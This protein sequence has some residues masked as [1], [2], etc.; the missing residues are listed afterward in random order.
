[1]EV[2]NRVAVESHDEPVFPPVSV[3]VP[4]AVA[5]P[6]Q[7]VS[8]LE[9]V[10][11]EMGL[12]SGDLECLD[13]L[14]CNSPAEVAKVIEVR[15]FFGGLSP[16]LSLEAGEGP[17]G[18]AKKMLEWLGRLSSVV[19]STAIE[20]VE[21]RVRMFLHY[22][23]GV[24]VDALVRLAGLPEGQGSPSSRA[25]VTAIL[26]CDPQT[27]GLSWCQ[28]SRE[29]LYRSAQTV[30]HVRSVLETA[31]G[32]GKPVSQ[33]LAVI[34]SVVHVVGKSGMDLGLAARVWSA[35]GVD[36]RQ[37]LSILA[38]GTP[39]IARRRCYEVLK[40]L[41]GAVDNHKVTDVDSAESFREVLRDF[42]LEGREAHLAGLFRSAWASGSDFWFG[43][44]D[45]VPA[46]AEAAALARGVASQMLV[47]EMTL[48]VEEFAARRQVNVDDVWRAIQKHEVVVYRDGEQRLLPSWQFQSD[49][50]SELLSGLGMITDR[51]YEAQLSPATASMFMVRP[52]DALIDNHGDPQSPRSW[53][54][55]GRDPVVVAEL[56]SALAR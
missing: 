32:V 7:V 47:V 41:P 25:E 19:G 53:L 9:Q 34:D 37:A 52:T 14:K 54:A 56:I 46:D 12:D 33:S 1:M 48:S 39:S 6:A 38:E 8:H 42:G 2:D 36:G 3:D 24:E 22:Q 11:E 13:L 28:L 5:V 31:F 30:R 29:R 35:T 40:E 4:D 44:A 20:H 23:M 16:S 15:G 21:D 50:G 10:R 43:T 51:L 49:E 18:P 17:D 26:R 55:C 27:K 45:D